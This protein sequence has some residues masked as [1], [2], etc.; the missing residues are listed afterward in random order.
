MKMK[1]DAS[2]TWELV[3]RPAEGIS[4]RRH[5][6]S[7]AVWL[8]L[9]S[10]GKRHLLVRASNSS[11]GEELLKT[12]GLS[13]EVSL[14]S[15]NQGEEATWIDISCLASRLNE[16]FAAV[17]ND[18]AEAV[19]EQTGGAVREVR[20]VLE[21]W[22]WF[23]RSELRT[24]TAERALGLFGELWFLNRWAPFPAALRT[25]EGPAGN[26]HDFAAP[27]IS[28]ECK[29][30]R[31]KTEGAATHQ[32]A[33]LDQLDAP[34]TGDLFLFSLQV[35][36]DPLAGNSLSGLIEATVGE[37]DGDQAAL[38]F[39]SERL[40]ASGWSPEMAPDHT[41]TYRVAGERLFSVTPGFPRLVP[42]SF[43]R[44][45]PSGVDQVRYRLDLAACDEWCVARAPS[46]TRQ[47]L[48]EL[49]Q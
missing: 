15:L 9:D 35:V 18:V 21:S 6:S 23:W 12:R 37:L 31:L 44:G 10:G 3:N 48:A 38:D 13:A 26:R 29:T 43:P 14:L 39:L 30:S 32:I 24:L 40:A 8:G 16:R 17:A 27:A 36:A 46:E 33:G 25:W 34:E 41:Q 5:P 22:R 47:L 4:A 1:R 11:P 7:P 28:V 42:S 19:G 45:I 2:E 49:V 20:S